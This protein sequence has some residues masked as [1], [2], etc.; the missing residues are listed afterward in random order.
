[1]SFQGGPVAVGTEKTWIRRTTTRSVRVTLA[2]FDVQKAKKVWSGTIEDSDS[3]SV[4]YGGIKDSEWIKRPKA[5]LGNL[6]FD[7][8]Y[9]PMLQPKAHPVKPMLKKI[10]TSFA[11]QLP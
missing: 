1:V 10:F 3:T 9:G 2:I 11:Q 5:W 4:S 8:V 6:F 7:S